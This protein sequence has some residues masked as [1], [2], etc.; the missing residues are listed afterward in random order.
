LTRPPQR[1]TSCIAV[2]K[3][4]GWTMIAATYIRA[5]PAFALT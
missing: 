1:A 5:S 2:A 3:K 4:P